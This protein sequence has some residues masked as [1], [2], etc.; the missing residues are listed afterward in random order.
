MSRDA[1]KQARALAGRTIGERIESA[2]R[3]AKAAGIRP[4]LVGTRYGSVDIEIDDEPDLPAGPCHFCGNLTTTADLCHGCGV[5][6][7]SDC[8]HETG[9]E[10]PGKHHPERHLG[11]DYGKGRPS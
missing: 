6:V 10:R 5:Q 11:P 2:E 8:E 4:R 7:C 1:H 3:A 9:N